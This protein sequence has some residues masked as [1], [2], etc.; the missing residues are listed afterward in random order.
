MTSVFWDIGSCY[1]AQI[2]SVSLC[3]VISC[4]FNRWCGWECSLH[5]AFAWHAQ[6]PE[7]DPYSTI[8]KG[9]EGREG[10]M[11]GEEN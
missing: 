8:G 3:L 11:R 7:C 1:V 10:E 2:D 6:G 4:S 5:V 9:R